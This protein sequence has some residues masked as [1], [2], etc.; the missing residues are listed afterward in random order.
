MKH[1]ILIA[2]SDAPMVTLVGKSKDSVTLSWESPQ[3]TY[4]TILK[5]QV[6]YAVLYS[7]LSKFQVTSD[8]IAQLC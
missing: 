4:G 6:R 1:S 5:Y 8:L 7:T 3:N 2:A